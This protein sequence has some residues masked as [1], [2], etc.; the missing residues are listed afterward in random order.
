MNG[1]DEIKT[2]CI[3]FDMPIEWA[4]E[5]K[6]EYLTDCLFDIKD[7]LKKNT[8]RLTNPHLKPTERE[9]I[10]T[11]IK[12]L[13]KKEKEASYRLNN[14]LT[15]RSSSVKDEMI[16][17]AKEYPIEELVEVKNNFAL[18]PFHPDR[19]PSFYVK[20]GYG[21]CFSCGKT[22]DSISVAMQINKIS[23]KDAVN[24]LGAL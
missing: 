12:D 5:K 14:L 6:K 24:Y 11:F 10:F 20:N 9:L 23:F 22:A 7:I 18:C 13:K 4:M 19:N 8:L 1:I 21:H 3:D 17:R 15:A 16:I 2:K